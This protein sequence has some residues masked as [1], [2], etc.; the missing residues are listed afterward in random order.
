[1]L[2]KKLFHSPL[3]GTGDPDFILRGFLGVFG[4]VRWELGALVAWGGCP[5]PWYLMASFPFFERGVMSQGC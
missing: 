4:E 2:A 5:A 1:M 3:F